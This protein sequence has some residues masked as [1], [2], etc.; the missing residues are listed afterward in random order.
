MAVELSGL[1]HSVA[2]DVTA[3]SHLCSLLLYPHLCHGHRGSQWCVKWGQVCRQN[4]FLNQ[5]ALL[6][7]VE[8]GGNTLKDF[9]FQRQSSAGSLGGGR[10]MGASLITSCVHFQD[11]PKYL[12]RYKFQWLQQTMCGGGKNLASLCVVYCGSLRF[13]W[14][15]FKQK[16]LGMVVRLSSWAFL[17]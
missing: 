6:W 2:W 15:D 4:S 9:F 16:L 17:F 1:L 11:A 12:V 14:A 7:E 3:L 13:V 10:W 5:R 8:W